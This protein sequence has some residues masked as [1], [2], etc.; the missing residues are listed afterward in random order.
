MFGNL[1]RTEKEARDLVQRDPD[2]CAYVV[3][4]AKAECG[5]EAVWF[6]RVGRS[7]ELAGTRLVIK[8]LDGTAKVAWKTPAGAVQAIER[9]GFRAI[10][11]VTDGY[12]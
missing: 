9:F 10:V 8:G 7:Q 6:V 4:D 2:T 1:W 5:P 11:I 12:C 3:K